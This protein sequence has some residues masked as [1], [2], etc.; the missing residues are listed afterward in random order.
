[1]SAI[2]YTHVIP[3]IDEVVKRGFC[4]GLGLRD[5]QMCVEAAICYA[6]GLPHGDDPGCV[7]P[8]VRRYKIVLN[9]ANWSSSQAR[10]QGLRD[11][12][13]AQLGSKGVVDET[14]FTKQL[15]HKTIQ[16]MLPRLFREIFPYN[17]ECLDAASAC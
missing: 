1:M 5:G 11:L 7:S 4:A 13:I 8:A 9:D 10:A 16:V 6:L 17:K 14:V 15:S 12:A 3:K 2:D